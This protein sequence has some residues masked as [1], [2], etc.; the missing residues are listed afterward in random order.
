MR[1]KIAILTAMVMQ[2]LWA[3]AQIPSTTPELD[4]VMQLRVNCD[5]AV[6]VGA[7][8]VGSRVTIPITGG[9]FSGPRIRGE[10]L[11]GGADFQLVHNDAG[12]T[13]LEAL[14]NIRTDD[15]V[16]IHVRNR[17]LIKQTGGDY[18]FYTSPVFEAPAESQYAWLNDA[19]YVCRPDESGI[20][21]GVVLNVWRVRDPYD[22][23]TTIPQPDSVPQKV[24][25]AADRRGKVETF[26]YIAEDSDG[27]RI[28]K[29]ARVYTPYSYNGKDKSIRYN[30][31]YLMH[32]G[33]DNTTSFCEDPRSP[34][35]LANVLDHLIADGSLEPLIVVMPTFYPDDRNIGA[36]RMEDAVAMTRDFHKE[37]RR[38]LIPSVETAY[39]TWLE[40]PDS[41]AITA[42]RL[43]RAF[44]GFSM[45]ALATWYQLAY[46]NDAVG[47]Y[48]PL[49]G[50]LWTFDSAGSRQP[51]ELSAS[52]LEDRLK[53]TPF[54]N[55][56]RVYAYTGT[57][58]IACE[59][60][61]SLIRAL[62]SQTSIFRCGGN[63]PNVWFYIKPGGKHYYGDINAYLYH[64]LPKLSFMY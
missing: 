59:P 48:L 3:V 14:Y 35:S 4:Y 21:G 56:F 36:N 28:K 22:F 53:G 39:N 57:D 19:I 30:V 18:Y 24:Y 2:V 29:R 11:K 27:K 51:Y 5:P 32:G 60:E 61:K 37:L 38:S 55:S 26:H 54:A 41:A 10:V 49:S 52:W 16:T 9:T 45:G 13:D 47:H 17:G 31:L 12:R 58:D 63:H 40:G 23:D 46:D 20:P 6:A 44:G 43:H 33:G 1:F 34:L 64:A 15:G 7:T 42:S 62:T 25:G 50:D 8:S